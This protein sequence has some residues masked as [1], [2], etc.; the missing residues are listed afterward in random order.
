M[1]PALAHSTTNAW[2]RARKSLRRLQKGSEPV[3][4]YS[5]LFCVGLLLSIALMVNIGH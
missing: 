2:Q 4:G 5:P 1:R 3:N